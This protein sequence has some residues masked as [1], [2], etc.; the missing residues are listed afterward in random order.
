MKIIICICL[1]SLYCEKPS[2]FKTIETELEKVK[3]ANVVIKNFETKRYKGNQYLWKLKADEAYLKRDEKK[4]YIFGIDLKY[5]D[6]DIEYTKIKGDQGVLDEK[7][8]KMYIQKNVFIRNYKGR[9]LYIDDLLWDGKKKKFFSN[10]PFKSVLPN[11]YTIHGVGL[12]ADMKFNKIK[13]KKTR[14]VYEN[15]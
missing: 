12:V 6:S 2:R 8:N 7:N 4:I 15:Q 5:Y 1:L 10:S 3:G 14:G 11:G 9:K 13:L